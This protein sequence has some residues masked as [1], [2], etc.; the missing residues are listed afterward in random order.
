MKSML[1]AKLPF[2]LLVKSW[3]VG[4]PFLV[5]PFHFLKGMEKCHFIDR[6]YLLLLKQ[7]KLK[8]QMLISLRGAE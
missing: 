3:N 6:V 4:W 7:V 5:L 8:I 1:A 2:N